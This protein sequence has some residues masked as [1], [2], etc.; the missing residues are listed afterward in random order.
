MINVGKNFG[1]LNKCKACLIEDDNQEHLFLCDRLNDSILTDTDYNDLFSE[2]LEKQKN[3]IN[4]GVNV[5]RQRDK[6]TNTN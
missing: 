6:I 5:L 3:V 2:Q 1:R 4:I